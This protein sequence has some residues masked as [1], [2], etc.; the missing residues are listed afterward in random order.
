M[1]P[2]ITA[3]P[4]NSS[5]AGSTVSMRGAGSTID[6]VMPVST[7]ISGGTATPGLT[8]VWK[9]PR[10]S[11]PQILTAPI[12]VMPQDSAEPPVVSRSITQNVTS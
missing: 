2:T 11:P 9:V 4:T 7:V 12:S 5:R 3:S 6:W 8:S 1:C 10:H